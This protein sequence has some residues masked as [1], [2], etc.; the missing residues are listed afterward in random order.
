MWAWRCFSLRAGKAHLAFAARPEYVPKYPPHARWRLNCCVS[1]VQVKIWFQNHRYKCKRQAKEKAM[2]E[3]NAQNQVST[4]KS[5]SVA[6][7]FECESAEQYSIASCTTLTILMTP[8]Y[9]QRAD[10]HTVR[11][12]NFRSHLMQVLCDLYTRI[13][14]QQLLTEF[15]NHILTLYAFIC[16]RFMD[17]ICILGLY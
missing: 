12:Y 16:S 3:Q 4:H 11:Q 10:E 5:K 7:D 6:S 13:L 1:C 15:C 9:T 17:A 2:A 8:Y 14:W